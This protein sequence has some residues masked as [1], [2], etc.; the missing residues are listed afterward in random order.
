[1]T[2][3]TEDKTVSVAHARHLIE[4]YGN[5]P[6]R[7]RPWYY[8]WALVIDRLATA[9]EQVTEVPIRDLGRHAAQALQNGPQETS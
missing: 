3:T 2:T 4:V 8:E 1:M 9:L 7:D 6:E 5:E